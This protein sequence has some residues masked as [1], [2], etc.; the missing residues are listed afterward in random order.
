VTTLVAGLG[1]LAS[2]FAIYRLWRILPSLGTLWRSVLLCGCAYAPAVLWPAA[3][4]LLF[5]KLP[6]IGLYIVI[7]FS[8][9]GEL[10]TGEVALVRALFLR[11]VAPEPTSSRSVVNE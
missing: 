7:A 6:A 9:L 8:A 11:Q 10:N 4:L 1:A 5:L 2:V 3:G